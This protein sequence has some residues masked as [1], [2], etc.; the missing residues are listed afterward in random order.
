MRNTCNK[1]RL[2]ASMTGTEDIKKPAQRA[3]FYTFL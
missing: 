3:G 2:R 1:K